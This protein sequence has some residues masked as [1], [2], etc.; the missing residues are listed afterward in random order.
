MSRSRRKRP[1]AHFLSSAASK[2][3]KDDKRDSARAD[4]RGARQL[5]VRAVDDVPIP[6]R[7]ARYQ[8]NVW[9][10]RGDGGPHWIG[11]RQ[12]GDEYD[13]WYYVRAMRK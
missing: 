7:R 6:D 11:D 10:W 13:Q 4:R 9:T 8:G 3:Q 2:G 5:L 1:Y 12:H